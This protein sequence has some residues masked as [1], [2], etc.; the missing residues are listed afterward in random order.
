VLFGT[1]LGQSDAERVIELANQAGVGRSEFVR[2][3]VLDALEREDEGPPDPGQLPD[4]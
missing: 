1:K 4:N 3:A 2:S